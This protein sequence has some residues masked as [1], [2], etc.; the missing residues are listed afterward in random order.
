MTAFPATSDLTLP[1]L[2]EVVDETRA[3]LN[4]PGVSV[5]VLHDGAVATAV[6]G[7]ANLNTGAAVTDDTRFLIGSISKIITC[8]LVLQHVERG[9]VDLD[10]P[11]QTYLPEFT[12]ADTDAAA[13]ITVRHLLTHTS[14]IEGDYFEQFGRGDEAIE[15]YVTSLE[16]VGLIHDVGEQFS[17]CNTGWVVAGRILEI[18][19]GARYREIVATELAAVVD[20]TSTT[21]TPEETILHHP[22][23]G[24]V[25]AAD[26]SLRVTSTYELPRSMG[27]AGTV[28]CSTPRDLLKFASVHLNEGIAPD[29]TKLLPPDLVALMQT[30]FM[31][32]PT[33][34]RSTFLGHGWV[35]FERDGIRFVT[36]SGGTTGQFSNLVL[37]PGHGFAIASQTNGPNGRVFNQLVA[38]RVAEELVGA[39]PYG[40]ATAAAGAAPADLDT[41]KGVYERL[42]VRTEVVRE[43]GRLWAISRPTRQATS[44]DGDQD[45]QRLVLEAIDETFFAARETPDGPLVQTMAFLQPDADGRPKYVYDG[46]IARRV[47]G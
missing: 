9:E 20:M 32:V 29:G 14:G 22:A 17:Y 40:G 33:P 26:G 34:D 10:A 18:L 37:A 2:D 4:V 19:R 44:D 28:I 12:L 41:Y 36:H 23:V 8:T 42:S 35:L 24:H 16:G 7:V 43:D 30:P 38:N 39:S 13:R 27:P 47:E 45:H 11:V 6:S 15:A 31:A 25:A 46:R 5:A 21:T 1:W 3:K